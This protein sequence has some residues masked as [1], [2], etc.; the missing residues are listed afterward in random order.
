MSNE[1]NSNTP[2][3]IYNLSRDSTDKN[4]LKKKISE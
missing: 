3:S 2:Q 4:I 1:Q